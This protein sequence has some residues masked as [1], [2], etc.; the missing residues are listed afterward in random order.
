M[1]KSIPRVSSLAPEAFLSRFVAANQPVIIVDAMRSWDALTQW[2]PEWLVAHYG[3]QKVQVYNTLFDLV[4]VITLERYIRD[5]FGKDPSYQATDYVRWY[6]KFKDVEFFWADSFFESVA[7]YWKDL[8]FFP[9]RDFVLPACA[10][11]EARSAV[12]GAFPYKGLFVS[13]RGAR[14]RLHRDPFAS[15]AILCQLHGSKAVTFYSPSEASRLQVRGQCVDPEAP[16]I[17]RFPGFPDAETRY[18]DALHPGEVLFVPGEWF[19]DVKSISDSISLTWNFVHS[20]REQAFRDVT[21]GPLSKNEQE[22][23]DYYVNG[24]TA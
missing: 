3:E 19:H 10:E 16:D 13:G 12:T 20:V 6:T 24:R 22:V 21:A 18:E 1:D 9:T 14:T 8:C 15:D 11:G 7:A 17:Q 4:D 5:N 23:I 2:T